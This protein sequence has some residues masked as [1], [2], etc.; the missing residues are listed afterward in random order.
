[1][2]KGNEK[3]ARSRHNMSVGILEDAC[4]ALNK[5]FIKAH[6]KQLPFV[7]LKWA[8]TANGFMARDIDDQRSAQISDT[9][10]NAL[11]HQLRA[12][13]QAILVGANTINTDTPKLNVRGVEG[14]NPLK[15]VL[16]EKLNINLDSKTL[17]E[18]K[19]LIYNA[20]RSEIK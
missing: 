8:E 7:T 13:H 1:M 14:R 4:K 10:N 19:T 9:V 12:T 17:T 2:R 20:I 16:S 6:T 18:G 3:T 15:I 11:V 5:K